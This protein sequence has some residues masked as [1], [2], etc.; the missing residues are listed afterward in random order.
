MAHFG[1]R[2]KNWALEQLNNI[3]NL[4]KKEQKGG[5]PMLNKGDQINYGASS[6]I[7]ISV[8]GDIVIAQLAD[9]KEYSLP[10]DQ[11]KLAKKMKASEVVGDMRGLVDAMRPHI[12]NQAFLG[13]MAEMMGTSGIS[14]FH[15]KAGK[16]HAF[17]AIES[18]EEKISRMKAEA[19]A[20]IE[21]KARK[22]WE[23]QNDMT[24]R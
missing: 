12:K 15:V 2:K 21:K 10:A 8:T 23:A 6:G 11:V 4:F 13:E 9:G 22:E 5:K 18:L 19:N 1:C 3:V 16:L 24:I 14:E 20:D 17:K 7:V